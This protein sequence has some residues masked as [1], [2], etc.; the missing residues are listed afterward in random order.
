MQRENKNLEPTNPTIA[1]IMMTTLTINTKTFTRI[2]LLDLTIRI[3]T[4]TMATKHARIARIFRTIDMIR[5]I[6]FR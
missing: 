4:R 5:A 3:M 2:E 1:K 6:G